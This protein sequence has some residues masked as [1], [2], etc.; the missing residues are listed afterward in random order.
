MKKRLLIGVIVCE[1]EQLMQ[2]RLIKGMMAQAFSLDIDIAVFSCITDLPELTA[3]QKA[4]FNI[5]EYMHYPSLDGILYLRDSIRSE[6]EKQK[7]DALLTEQKI[8][9]LVLDS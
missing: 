1:A 5:F 4:E 9:V 6:E 3:H 2:R 8:P 7:L